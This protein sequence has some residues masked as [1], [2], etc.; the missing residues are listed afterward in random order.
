MGTTKKLPIQRDNTDLTQIFPIVPLEERIYIS[1]SQ[2]RHTL[3]KFIDSGISYRG[4][5]LIVH[6][7]NCPGSLIVHLR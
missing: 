2:I 6:L 5:S 7:S 4:S 3:Q 1:D